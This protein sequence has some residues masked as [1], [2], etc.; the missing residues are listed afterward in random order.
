MEK[1]GTAMAVTTASEQSSR[2]NKPPLWRARGVGCLVGAVLIFGGWTWWSHYRYKTALLEIE[3][4]MARGRYPAATRNLEALLAW[5]ADGNGE[6]GY[7]L[8]FCELA[9]GNIE[10]TESAWASIAPGTEFSERAILGRMRVLQGAGRLAKAERLVKD[11]ARDPRNNRT[12]LMIG[13]VP[14]MIDMGRLDEAIE[15][16]E[17]RWEYLNALGQGALDPSIRLLLQHVDLTNGTVAIDAVRN[18]LD[19]AAKLAPDDDRVCLGRANLAI[20]TGD[21][22]GAEHWLGECESNRP[23]DRA[24][25]RA[26]LKWAMATDRVDAVELA[27]THLPDMESLSVTR[28]RINAWLAGHRGDFAKERSEL[29]RLLEADP[30]DLIAYDRLIDLDT[31]LG[32]PALASQVLQNRNAARELLARYTM[33]HGRKQPI[34]DAE[35][36]AQIA[37]RLGRA[38]EARGFL[39][40]AAFQEPGRK[41]LSEKLRTYGSRLGRQIG[42]KD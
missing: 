36:L 26:R 20:R 32:Q 7:L 33:L 34:R 31:K 6:L 1:A 23:D 37:E 13:L 28:H 21:M 5:K 27:I 9:R 29:V 18:S 11:A 42:S 16:I 3:N 24:V 12:A 19:E 41:D 8:G 38:F 4:Q 25:W 14:L 15:L 30:G 22:Q 35:E 10:A 40:I 39:T 17:D 2:T